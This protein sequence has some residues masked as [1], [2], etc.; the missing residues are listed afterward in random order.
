ML[1]FRELGAYKTAHNNGYCTC[2]S[3]LKNGYGVTVNEATKVTAL[4]TTTTTKGDVWIV[5]NRIDKPE[6]HQ[7]ND[8]K[9]EIG[10]NPRLFRVKS[11]GGRIIDMDMDA[12]TTA[13][14]DVAVADKLT[15]GTDGKLV[16]TVDVTGY[17]TY[18]EVTEKTVFGGAGLAVKVVVA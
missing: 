7:P 2:A 15:F 14:A 13:Y 18:F 8:Y 16:K 5:L 3:V 12:V 6:T 10:E 17:D 4:P 11:L 9:I 1:K